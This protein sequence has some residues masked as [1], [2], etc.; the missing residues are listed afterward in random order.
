[1]GARYANPRSVVLVRDGSRLAIVVA[2]V[3]LL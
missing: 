2:V 3:T 1:M